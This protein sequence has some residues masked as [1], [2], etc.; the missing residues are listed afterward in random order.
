MG[1]VFYGL[2]V[3]YCALRV[4]FAVGGMFGCSWVVACCLGLFTF[5]GLVCLVGW[6]GV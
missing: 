4:C 5:I 6:F 2:A 1:W 3:C